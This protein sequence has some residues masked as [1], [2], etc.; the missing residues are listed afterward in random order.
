MI[1]WTGLAPWGFEFS[2]HRPSTPMATPGRVPEKSERGAV[3]RGRDHDGSRG[4]SGYELLR[5]RANMANI[6]QSSPDSGLDFPA[7][8]LET[9]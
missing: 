4:R 5:C 9:V 6:K 2:D 3:S 1:S 8:N 7:K